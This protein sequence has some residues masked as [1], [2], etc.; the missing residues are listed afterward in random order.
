MQWR[1]KM[2]K[3]SLSLETTLCSPPSIS[4]ETET[5]CVCQTGPAAARM[6]SSSRTTSLSF[7]F[8]PS[9]PS[10]I[11]Q[12]KPIRAAK[13]IA[14]GLRVARRLSSRW[15]AFESRSRA[16]AARDPAPAQGAAPFY[17]GMERLGSRT[18]DLALIALRLVLAGR[19]ADD[20]AVVWL[21]DVAAR[22]RAG[23]A[24]ARRS[25]AHSAGRD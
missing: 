7:W 16:L 6:R 22:A 9:V 25:T 13:P 18:P 4:R 1:T 10:T 23:D 11:A 21:R 24:A 8:A 15:R 12:S 19:R 20:A 3:P 17:E 2:R 5:K 14:D